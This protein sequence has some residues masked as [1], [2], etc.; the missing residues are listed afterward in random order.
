MLAQT[1]GFINATAMYFALILQAAGLPKGV[2]NVVQGGAS[3]GQS[4]LEM[5]ESGLI[6]KIAFTGSS[7]VGK[8]IG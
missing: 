5:V 3:A 2:L 4:I 6:Q 1:T 8:K 7:A